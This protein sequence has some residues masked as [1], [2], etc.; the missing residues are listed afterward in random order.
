[1]IQSSEGT[2]PFDR[3]SLIRTTLHEGIKISVFFFFSFS[4]RLLLCM[5]LMFLPRALRVF[6]FFHTTRF[7]LS[8][9]VHLSKE[10]ANNSTVF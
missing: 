2:L 6:R 7:D 4:D 10:L 1:M 9:L 3:K 8:L 5:R